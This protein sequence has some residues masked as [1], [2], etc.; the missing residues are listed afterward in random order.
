MSHAE[1]EARTPARSR[2][3]SGRSE[4]GRYAILPKPLKVLFSTFTV[5][6]VAL[7]TIYIHNLPVLGGTVFTPDQYYYLLYVLVMLPIFLIIPAC[8]KDRKRLP[9]YDAVLGTVASGVAVYFLANSEP[10]SL[11]LWTPPPT[12]AGFVTATI[13]LI[14]GL[15]A[16]RRIGGTA[17]LIVACAFGAYPLFAEYMPGVL[18]G[19]GFSFRQLVGQFAFSTNGILG[20]PIQ[21]TGDILIGYLVFSSVMVATGAGTFFLDLAIGLMGRFRGGPAKV[22]VVASAFFGSLSG[23]GVANVMGTGSFTI[24][25]MK[26][27]GYPPHYAGAIE[28]CASTGGAVMPPVMGTIAFIMAIMTGVDYGQIVLAAVI[29]ALLY[30]Y[31]LLV[32]VDGY[33]ARVGLVGMPKEDLPSIRQTLKVG[34]PFLLVFAFLLWGIEAKNWT[35]Q[36]PLYASGLMTALSFLHKENRL[37]WKKVLGLI[38][39]TG[40]LIAWIIAILLPVGLIITG[41]VITGTI[42]AII[43]KIIIIGSANTFIIL[44]VT[45]AACYLMGMVGLA[46]I[47]YIFLA[48]TMAPAVVKY[49]G[50]DIV[51]VHLFI[52][53]CTLSAAITP[54]VATVAFVGASLAQASP[55]KTAWTALRLG[56][57]LLFV[58]FFFVY[59]PALILRGPNVVEVIW[60]FP[61]CLLGIWVLTSGLEGYLLW[62]GKI[63]IW[64]R[65]LLVIGGFLIAVPW[66]WISAACGVVITGVTT[67]TLLYLHR[68]RPLR[69][70][71]E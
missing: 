25:A 64:T 35:A 19:V 32:Q 33:A 26:R 24:P 23:S 3:E 10:I 5:A 31:G 63:P 66:G 44:L 14:L 50:L 30:Y 56:I 42:A 43:A 71:L 28:A 68:R 58:P 6:T 2:S 59:N 47:P 1:V 61:L 70:V 29:P 57:V 22:A 38:S 18:Y 39:A 67:T 4:A 12:T 20:V 60:L 46:L 48:V 51:G 69:P 7:F 49:G 21:V 9:W 8:K 34:W 53:Y 16:G 15:E 40:G 13:M 62:V 11:S 41:L 55:M 65:P 54:P 17:F 37:T 45:L 52:V 36:S 27:L